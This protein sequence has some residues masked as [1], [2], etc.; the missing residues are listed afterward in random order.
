MSLSICHTT[1]SQLVWYRVNSSVRGWDKCL[2]ARQRTLPKDGEAN[3]NVDRGG[4]S[5]TRTAGRHP[6][7]WLGRRTTHCK[8]IL[9]QDGNHVHKSQ[10]VLDWISEIE[11]KHTWTNTTLYTTDH[12]PVNMSSPSNTS[13]TT[14]ATPGPVMTKPTC[15]SGG[16]RIDIP[17][18]HFKDNGANPIRTSWLER[19]RAQQAFA[20]QTSTLRTSNPYDKHWMDLVSPGV[21]EGEVG[22]E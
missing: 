15:G 17:R 5:G 3:I 12:S 2:L 18:Y 21:Q 9:D 10:S 4:G 1:D 19:Q 20:Q 22:P 7:Q 8:D 14:T 11:R 13:N 6:C 16:M